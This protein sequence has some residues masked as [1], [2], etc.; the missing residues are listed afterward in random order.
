M[1]ARTALLDART[2]AARVLLGD[3]AAPAP[4]DLFDELGTRLVGASLDP[5]LR[6]AWPAARDDEPARLVALLEARA[7]AATLRERFDVDW[8]RNPRAWA[9]LRAVSAVPARE[10]VDAAAL[11]VEADALA[12]AFEAALG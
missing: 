4:R 8:W 2:R 12:R 6:G 11:P 1:V 3:D 10:P 7:F 9:H 5:R